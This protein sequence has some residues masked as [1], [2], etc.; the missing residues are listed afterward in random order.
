MTSGGIEVILQAYIMRVMKT[1][2]LN[3]I[4]YFTLQFIFYIFTHTQYTKK[5]L[6]NT[7]YKFYNF[8]SKQI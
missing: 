8:Y 3:T 6:Y 4:S 1:Y 5:H 7:Q 2:I